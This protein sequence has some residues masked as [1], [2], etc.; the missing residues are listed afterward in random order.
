MSTDLRNRVAIVTGGG[1]GIGRGLALALASAGATVVVS[2]RTRETLDDA[3]DEIRGRGGTALPVT[4]D[5]RERADTE[6]L[7]AETV[8]RAGD[9]TSS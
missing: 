9:S 5:V 6:R 4:A 8:S 3:C 7:V 1:R 2:G